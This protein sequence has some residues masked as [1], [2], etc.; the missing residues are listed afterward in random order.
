M[1]ELY[2]DGDY[3]VIMTD[4]KDERDFL[5]QM[6][7]L[8]NDMIEARQ[9]ENDWYFQ[10]SFWLP[11]IVNICCKYR[12]Y[13]SSVLAR[14]L[15]I[16]GSLPPNKMEPTSS[17]DR[18]E[19]TLTPSTSITRGELLKMPPKLQKTIIEG[20]EER[21]KKNQGKSRKGSEGDLNVSAQQSS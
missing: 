8:L 3:I 14:Q 5:D 10:F 9:Y 6:S 20:E 16:S 17:I 2:K 19:S 21:R 11:Q 15:L 18:D 4:E 13:K 1:I 7:R 12:G